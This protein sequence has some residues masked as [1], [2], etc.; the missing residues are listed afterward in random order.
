MKATGPGRIGRAAAKPET[1][2]PIVGLQNPMPLPPQIATP[3]SRAMAAS[4]PAK[5]SPGCPVRS[6]LAKIVTAFAP[7]ATASVSPASSCALPSP[8]TTCST[9]AG[10]AASEGKQGKSPMRSYRGFTA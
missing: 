9:G 10:S 8:S 4:R 7:C 2:R 5:G 3:A 6:Q 1:R